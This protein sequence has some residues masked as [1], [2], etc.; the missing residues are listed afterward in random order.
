MPGSPLS[1]RVAAAGVG[2][3][4]INHLIVI[5]VPP[6]SWN[7]GTIYH[8]IS[9]PLY[10]ALILPL[11][12]GRNWAR[13]TISILLACQFAGRFVVWVMFPSIG[14]HYALLAGWAIS[15]IV[16]AA[17]WIPRS[18]RDHFRRGGVVASRA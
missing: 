14:V 17:L 15:L 12:G 6:V 3:H 7:P 13:I 18:A 1:V 4:A 8:L 11:L 10:A 16:L 5:L 2:I 9:A